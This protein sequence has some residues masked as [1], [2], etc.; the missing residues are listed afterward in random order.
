M[1][2]IIR[3]RRTGRTTELIQRCAEHRYALI[4]T[5]DRNRARTVFEMA[6]EMEKY[7]PFPITITEFVQ[8][9]FDGRYIDA[10]LFDD[11]D[12]SLNRLSGWV[13]IEAVVI[14]KKTAKE[15]PKKSEQDLINR[16]EALDLAKDICVPTKDGSIFRHR[17]IDPDEIRE[18]PSAQPEPCTFCVHNDISADGIC[19]RCPAERR[20]D[21][22][23]V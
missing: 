18:L 21:E 16:K 10:F 4:V 8:S 19:L 14:E 23:Q 17:C 15:K 12:A 5:A 7:I 3:E 6:R 22:T 1:D 2:V 9:Q 13:P 11:L 20:T